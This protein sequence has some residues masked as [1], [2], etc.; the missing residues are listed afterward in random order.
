MYTLEETVRTML[1]NESPGM[2]RG[3]RGFPAALVQDVA[4][5]LG[6]EAAGDGNEPAEQGGQCRRCD[7]PDGSGAGLGQPQ[8]VHA[9]ES[10]LSM[11]HD[12]HAAWP[13]RRSPHQGAG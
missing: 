7:A 5:C 4:R 13:D 6:G 12:R 3:V 2:P 10:S 9:A 11:D 8:L 1:E